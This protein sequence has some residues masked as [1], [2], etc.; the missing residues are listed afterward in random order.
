[1]LFEVVGLGRCFG[2][3]AGRHSADGIDL[4]RP[5]PRSSRLPPWPGLG[6]DDQ[7]AATELSFDAPLYGVLVA[8]LANALVSTA[9]RA[10]CTEIGAPARWHTVAILSVLAVLGLRDKI[11]FLAARGEAYAPLAL[12]LRS[13][14]PTSSSGPRWCSW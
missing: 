14:G 6:P 4:Y 5:R 1:M 3:L 2:P 12:A 11:I 13:P 8:S 7:G 9:A 10:C